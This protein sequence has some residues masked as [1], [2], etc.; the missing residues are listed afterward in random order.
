M[1]NIDVNFIFLLIC[2]VASRFS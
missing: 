2:V 1:H